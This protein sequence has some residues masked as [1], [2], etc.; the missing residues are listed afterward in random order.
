[1]ETFGRGSVHMHN[2]PELH[3]DTILGRSPLLGIPI[4]NKA[5]M[6]SPY[7]CKYRQAPNLR[8]LL[9]QILSDISSK[10]MHVSSAVRECVRE[11]ECEETALFVAGYTA[12]TA[13]VQKEMLE[14]GIDVYVTQS[15]G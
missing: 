5:R 10:T 12:H 4:G 3:L 6:L 7:S 2:L 9:G 8:S 11:I 13:L 15:E 14:A 1:M